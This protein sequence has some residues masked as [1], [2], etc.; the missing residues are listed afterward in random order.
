MIRALIFLLAIFSAGSAFS[1]SNSPACPTFGYFHNCFG[2]YNFPSGERYVGEFKNN[3]RHG[4]GTFYASSGFI[5]SE[6]LWSDGRFIRPA[7]TQQINLLNQ[8]VISAMQSTVTQNNLPACKA[9]GFFENC[10]GTFTFPSGERY[11]GEFKNNLRHGLGT[12]YASNGL[13]VS[14]GVWSFDRFVRAVQLQQVVAPSSTQAQTAQA[15]TAPQ[16]QL[17]QLTAQ[18]KQRLENEKLIEEA[19]VARQRQRELEE[20][21]RQAQ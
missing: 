5:V 7:P 2:T 9:A 8:T 16:Q 17:H 20:Q 14:E 15:N 11:V 4:L 19:A 1:Q 21:L 18:E 12:F 13:A 3:L 10:F 6:G